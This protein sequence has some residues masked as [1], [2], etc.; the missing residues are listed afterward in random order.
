MKFEIHFEFRASL[1]KF[2]DF[3]FWDATVPRPGELD[4]AALC[5]PRPTPWRARPPAPSLPRAPASP[6]PAPPLAAA[7]CSRPAS[8]PSPSQRPASAPVSPPRARLPQPRRATP[9]PASPRLAPPLSRWLNPCPRRALAPPS[10][11]RR[12]SSP[13]PCPGG[14]ALTAGPGGRARPRALVAHPRPCPCLRPCPGD[15]RPARLHGSRA[16]GTHNAL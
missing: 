16:L 13:R 9:P 4:R 7:P 14:C 1:R 10:P 15:S 12:E 5:P 3:N 8:P 6:A 2:Q 11:P